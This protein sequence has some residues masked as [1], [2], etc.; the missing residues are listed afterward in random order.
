MPENTLNLN[1]G[2]AVQQENTTGFYCVEPSNF[3]IHQCGKSVLVIQPDGNILWTRNGVTRTVKNADM[4]GIALMDTFI[5]LTGSHYDYSLLS[6]EIYNRYKK[7]LDSEE[8][9]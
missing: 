3:E 8:K 6:S 9:E 4:L 5:F 7:F 2:D 1:C